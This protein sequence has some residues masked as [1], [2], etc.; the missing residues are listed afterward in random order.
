MRFAS[1]TALL[2]HHFIKLGF[3][4]GWKQVVRRRETAVFERLQRR[5]NEIARQEGEL[6]LTIPMVYVEGVARET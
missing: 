4:D 1:G 3:L 6:S 2:N 5:L